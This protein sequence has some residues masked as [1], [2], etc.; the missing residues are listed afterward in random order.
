MFRSPLE[1]KL[2]CALLCGAALAG[3]LLLWWIPAPSERWHALLLPLWAFNFYLSGQKITKIIVAYGIGIT[4][5]LAIGLWTTGSSQAQYLGAKLT[6]FE[7]AHKLYF[8]AGVFVLYAIFCA[9]LNRLISFSTKGRKLLKTPQGWWLRTLRIGLALML[10]APYLYA[11]FN[12]HRFKYANATNPQQR[13]G[14]R[15]EEVNFQANDGT[16]LSGWWISAKESRQTIVVVHGVGSNKGDASVVAPF[17]HRAGFNVLLFD[18]RGHGDSSGHTVSFGLHEARDVNAAV[19]LAA[20]NS[21]SVGLYAFSMGGSAALHAIGKTGLP[22]AK[23]VILDSTFAE[24]VPLAHSQMAFLPETLACPLLK[25]LSFY[26]WLEI[27]STLE[28]IAPHRYIGQIAPRPLLLMHGTR[29]SLIA[30]AHAKKNF[31]LAKQPKQLHWMQG[32]DHC[33]GLW[34]EGAAYEKRIVAFFK[35]NL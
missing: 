1:F 26:S 18:M 33:T 12:F 22:K 5:G 10:F 24:M 13:H 20:K 25:S 21:Q 8:G 30:P 27:G 28:N 7:V 9:V 35:K 11:T 14:L 3:W 29:D 34:T 23:A 31:S 2:R 17:L 19:G 16:K 4:L 6:W 32:A 15:Y